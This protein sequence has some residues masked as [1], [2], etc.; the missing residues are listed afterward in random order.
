M[1]TTSKSK[2]T[3]K[4]KFDL[5]VELLS[6]GQMPLKENVLKYKTEQEL[7]AAIPALIMSFGKAD[8]SEYHYIRFTTW[9]NIINFTVCAADIVDIESVDWAA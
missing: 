5:L 1:K 7:Y 4:Y 8:H 9:G 3:S 6:E 2:G